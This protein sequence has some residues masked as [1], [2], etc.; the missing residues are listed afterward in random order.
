MFD[1]IKNFFESKLSKP[2]AVEE[3]SSIRQID[4]ASAALLIEV[5]KADHQLDER[6]SEKFL[7]VLK[8]SYNIPDAELQEL[9]Q[10]AEA[11]SRQATS[12]YQFT[13]L[14][15]EHYDYE[16]KVALIENMWRIAFSDDE[17]DRYE[18][19][20]IRKISDLIYVSHSDFIR[21]KHNARGSDAEQSE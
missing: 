19:H 10:L 9:K 18:D 6:E 4:L 5:M 21:S 15:N 3:D 11:E 17:L 14:I 2:D 12:L 16:E 8:S 7:D 1:A 20:L 13:K